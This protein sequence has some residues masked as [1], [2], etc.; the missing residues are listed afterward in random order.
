MP[1]VLSPTNGSCK[2]LHAV[3]DAA[4]YGEVAVGFHQFLL[5]VDFGDDG[6]YGDEV[7]W[8][9]DLA[10]VDPFVVFAYGDGFEAFAFLDL[11]FVIQD[12]LH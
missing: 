11:E 10:A 4:V 12:Y 6:F 3:D 2:I 9:G 7:V 1:L 5:L 8:G